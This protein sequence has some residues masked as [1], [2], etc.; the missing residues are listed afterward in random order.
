MKALFRKAGEIIFQHLANLVTTIGIILTAWLNVILWNQPA[1]H[2]LL[3]F[4]FSLGIW[5]SDL[6]D[7]WLAR[8]L[9]IVGSVGDFLDRFRDKFYFCS[10]FAYFFKELWCGIDGIWSAFIK[11]SI[12]LILLIECFLIFI[13]FVGFI[14]G[15]EIKLHSSSKVKASFCFIAINWWFFISWLERFLQK[16]LENYLYPGLILLLFGASI[17]GIFSIVHYLQRYQSQSPALPNSQN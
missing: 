4:L 10:L 13:W 14:K 1:E 5:F 16:E 9:K 7:G 17:Y 12:V 3:I 6:L 11:A 8:R 15:L 2:R